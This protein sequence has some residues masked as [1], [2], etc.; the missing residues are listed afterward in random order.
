[1]SLL[2]EGALAAGLPRERIRSVADEFEALEACLRA[3]RPGDLVVL[4]PASTGEA[5]RRVLAFRPAP[6]R[7]PEVSTPALAGLEVA[8]A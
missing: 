7:P 6:A 4:T 3:A 8:H 2:T 1:M 5:W